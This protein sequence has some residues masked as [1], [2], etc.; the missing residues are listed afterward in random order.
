MINAIKRF[1]TKWFAPY[2]IFFIDPFGEI[3]EVHFAWTLKD[4]L[5]W[6]ACSLRE[7]EVEIFKN[8]NPIAY[9]SETLEA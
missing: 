4:A 2:I 5:E 7:E 9:R 6:A 8:H 1:L 3:S